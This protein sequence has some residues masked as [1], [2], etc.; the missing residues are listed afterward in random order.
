MYWYSSH[1]R[2]KVIVFYLVKTF[3]FMITSRLFFSIIYHFVVIVVFCW[4]M[5]DVFPHIIFL[6]AMKKWSI[7]NYSFC[8]FLLFSCNAVNH[9]C[10]T[11]LSCNKLN[12]WNCSLLGKMNPI[13]SHSTVVNIQIS[14]I[15]A[16]EKLKYVLKFCRE[17]D[18]CFRS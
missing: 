7:R 1:E 12:S 3:S 17:V 2:K 11:I 10:L 18:R 14:H 4:V 13:E 6:E 5:F 8:F 9:S 16:A 15:A